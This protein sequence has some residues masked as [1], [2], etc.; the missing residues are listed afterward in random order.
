MKQTNQS[1]RSISCNCDDF[2]RSQWCHHLPQGTVKTG[3]DEKEA[4]KLK[5]QTPNQELDELRP[6]LDEENKS[7]V[8]NP[9]DWKNELAEWFYENSYEWT[10][11]RLWLNTMDTSVCFD[12][13]IEYIE[14][15]L[16]LKKHGFEGKLVNGN[17]YFKQLDGRYY[18][19]N[20]MT[21]LE[22]TT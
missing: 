22:E 13:L 21:Y 7:I 11:E 15:L 3:W 6:S 1:I 9:N 4:I 5:N 12:E 17:Y 2:K 8:E 16:E 18:S 20:S 19:V 10:K 14:Q